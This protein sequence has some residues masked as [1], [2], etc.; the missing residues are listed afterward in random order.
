MVRGRARGGKGSLCPPP[1]PTTP[2]IAPPGFPPPPPQFAPPGPPPPTLPEPPPQAPPRPPPIRP[3][4]NPPSHAPP[5]PQKGASGQ[6]LGGGVVGVQ[7]RGVAPPPPPGNTQLPHRLQAP[8]K[9]IYTRALWVLAFVVLHFA[10]GH[11]RPLPPA[12]MRMHADSATAF[13]SRTHV[14]ACATLCPH[15]CGHSFV[16]ACASAGLFLSLVC[17]LAP[18]TALAAVSRPWSLP[19]RT[20]LTP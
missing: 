4:L 15:A 9:K 8:P 2:Q 7:N 11:A 20:C 12:R 16:S 1:P 3:S 19:S 17:P 14:F 5:P 6:Q 10:C 13:P 18:Q